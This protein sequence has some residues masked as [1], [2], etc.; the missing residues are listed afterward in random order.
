M[1]NPTGCHNKSRQGTV[2]Q[3][4]LVQ[5]SQ[6]ASVGWE[7]VNFRASTVQVLT[8]LYIAHNTKGFQATTLDHRLPMPKGMAYKE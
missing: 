7:Q 1:H 6:L 2:G 3:A 5:H 8:T 4:Q